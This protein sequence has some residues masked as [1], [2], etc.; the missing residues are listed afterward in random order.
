M[1]Q[2]EKVNKMSGSNTLN[3]HYYGNISTTP[4]HSSVSATT[5][6]AAA[7]SRTFTIDTSGGGRRCR[8]NRFNNFFVANKVNK[9][10]EIAI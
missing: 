2:I 7:S 5:T 10:G 9:V 3:H 6:T 1:R 8:E 4:R